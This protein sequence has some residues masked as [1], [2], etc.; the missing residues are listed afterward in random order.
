MKPGSKVNLALKLENIRQ[1]WEVLDQTSLGALSLKC[2]KSDIGY[3]Q[4]NWNTK[5]LQI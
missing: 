5:R 4:S 1:I 2:N 3:H